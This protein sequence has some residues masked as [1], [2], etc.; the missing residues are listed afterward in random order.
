MKTKPANS[1]EWIWSH[2]GW[3]TCFHCQMQFFGNFPQLSRFKYDCNE[4][5]A[6]Q[7]H[8]T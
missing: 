8:E 7:V 4:Y 5:L 1:H 2:R 6:L 3:Y